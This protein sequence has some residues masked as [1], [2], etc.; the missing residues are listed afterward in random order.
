MSK[1]IY[2]AKLAG[3]QVCILQ[4]QKKAGVETNGQ[5]KGGG[6]LVNQVHLNHPLAACVAKGR[7]TVSAGRENILLYRTD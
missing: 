1:E 6:E 4:A 2:D 5:G 7:G 3:K